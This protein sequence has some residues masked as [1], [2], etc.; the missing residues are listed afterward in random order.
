[1][2]IF[3]WIGGVLS[4]VYNFPQIYHTYKMK[5]SKDLSLISMMFRFSSY[6]FYILHGFYISD[7]P[8]IWNTTASLIQ[9]LIIIFQFYYYKK[10]NLPKKEQQINEIV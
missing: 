10:N 4:N 2:L 1:M 9:L 7:P 5:S 3:G 6:I 8:L